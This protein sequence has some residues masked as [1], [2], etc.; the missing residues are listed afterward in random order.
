MMSKPSDGFT[1]LEVMVGLAIVAV[2]LMAVLRSAASATDHADALLQV[3]L[4]NWVAAN[5]LNVLMAEH[6]WLSPGRYQGHERQA[7]LLFD[8]QE[9]VQPTDWSLFRR[10]DVDVVLATEPQH[11][12]AHLVGF[13]T[14]SQGGA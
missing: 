14:Q 6:A 5:Q 9:T 12:L 3:E 10:V 13:I 7:G 11:R 2:G 4:A 8:W 1:L